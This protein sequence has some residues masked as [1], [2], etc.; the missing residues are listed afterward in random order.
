MIV[1]LIEFNNFIELKAL[2]GQ[3]DYP[4]NEAEFFAGK[5]AGVQD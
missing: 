3:N 5:G 4:A 1:G 2:P